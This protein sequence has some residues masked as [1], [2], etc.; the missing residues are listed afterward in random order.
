MDEA[1]R[2][3]PL[4]PDELLR[5]QVFVA[6]ECRKQ[7]G[8]R[9]RW[10]RIEEESETPVDQQANEWVLKTRAQLKQVSSPQVNIY[11]QASGEVE[12]QLVYVSI[13]IVYVPAVEGVKDEE[14]RTGQGG[15]VGPVPE[16]AQSG[17]PRRGEI[18]ER[19]PSE[20]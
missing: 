5:V 11:Q 12:K 6:R 2:M 14:A 17:S 19:P 1:S 7:D 8:E 3:V 9:K 18:F 4:I 15:P 13:S 16:D 10:V 20:E